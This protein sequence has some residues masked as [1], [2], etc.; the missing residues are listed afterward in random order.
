MSINFSRQ[1]TW[2][3]LQWEI[4]YLAHVFQVNDAAFTM[5]STKFGGCQ[6]HVTVCYHE[7]HGL[8]EVFWQAQSKFEGH[9]LGGRF[10]TS[11]HQP[12]TTWKMDQQTI[13]SAPLEPSD[14]VYLGQVL[15]VFSYLLKRYIFGALGYITNPELLP[16]LVSFP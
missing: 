16:L 2:P 3:Q 8:S 4:I 6:N 7:I 1:K 10:A 9:F 12:F 15:R 11:I 5:I 14:F 13:P